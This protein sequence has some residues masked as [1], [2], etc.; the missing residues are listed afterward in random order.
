MAT[1]FLLSFL[2]ISCYVL[3]IS[4]EEETGFVG[5]PD[6]KSL[7]YKKKHTLSHFRF[8]WH[9]I[10]SGSNPSSVRVIPPQPKYNTTT[11]FGSVGVFDNVLTLGPE[12]YSKVVGSAEGLYSS[13]S[14]KEFA[15]L[16][17]L[18]FAL[19][20]GKYNGSTIT[21]VGRSPIAQKVRELPVIGGSGVFRFARGYAESRTL[22]FD[23]Q[24][25]NNTI[26]YNVY[27]YH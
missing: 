8:Y 16:V 2:L 14:Q 21:F 26:E 19:T 22:S 12:L 6:P 18:N 20:E 23:P 3:S 13:A 10:F 5:S 11:T 4:G 27:V 25:R 24:T 7:G 1:K 9:E 17:I 15:L